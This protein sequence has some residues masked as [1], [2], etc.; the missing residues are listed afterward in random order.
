MIDP[1]TDHAA[2]DVFLGD[3]LAGEIL[4]TRWGQVDARMF[5]K[6]PFRHA[7]PH[8]PVIESVYEREIW[9]NPGRPMFSLA[10]AIEE[11]RNYA[12]RY[13]PEWAEMPLTMRETRRLD[14]EQPA[15]T[16]ELRKRLERWFS[17]KDA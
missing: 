3:R 12:R 6:G 10:H 16:G 1:T 8:L 14:P 13:E 5:Y 9:Y 7:R 2:Y 4:T 17:A 11:I 15:E